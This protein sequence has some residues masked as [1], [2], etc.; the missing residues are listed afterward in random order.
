MPARS[1]LSVAEA[2]RRAEALLAAAA[3]RRVIIGVAGAP[4]AGKSTVAH[5]LADEIAGAVVVGMDGYHLAHSVLVERGDVEL[6]GAIDTFDA[7]GYVTLLQRIRADGPETVWAPEFRREIADAIAGAVEVPRC[8][9]LVVTEGNY[10]LSDTEPWSRLPGLCDEIWYAEVPES[11]RIARLVAR[12]VAYGR[13]PQQAHERATTGS[14]AVNARLVAATR[15]RA[16]VIVD[17]SA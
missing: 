9:R 5:R 12:H 11:Q 14:D 10:L 1:R 13:S 6:K 4:G 16:D 17:V 7:H 3:P 15:A 8:A 2:I